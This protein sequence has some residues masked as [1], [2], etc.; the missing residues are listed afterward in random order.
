M[1][2]RVLAGLL[3]V[4]VVAVIVSG[5]LRAGF[6]YNAVWMGLF[7]ILFGAYAIGGNALVKKLRG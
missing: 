5:I 3:A 1:V 4:G 7:A 2:L 6:A